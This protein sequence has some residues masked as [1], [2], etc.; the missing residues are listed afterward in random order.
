MIRVTKRQI[1]KSK[2]HLL[3]FASLLLLGACTGFAS[4]QQSQP[5]Y[6]DPHQTLDKRVDD[7]VSRM[8]MEEKISQMQ[9]GAKAIPRLSVP[10]YNWWNEGLHGIARSG[11]AT[12]FPQALGMAATWDKTL[13]HQLGTVTSTEA[14]A[15]HYDAI[16]HNNRSIYY[17]LTIWSPNINI[18]RDPRWGRGQETYGED[19]YLTGQIGVAYIKG[20]QGD[21]PEHPRV[22]AT[23]KHLAAHSG[24]ESQ[25]H[26]FNV[27]PSPHDLEDTY[28]PAFRM[29]ITEGKADSIM[30]AYNAIDG[31]PACANK[32]IEEVVRKSW[33]FQ[34]FVTSDCGAVDDMDSK[35]GHHFAPDNAHA[36]ALSVKAGTDLTCGTEYAKLP[37]ALKANL[38]SEAEIDKAVR[39]LFK[40]RFQLGMFDPPNQRAYAQIPFSEN[41]SPA[42][43]QMA[44]EAAKKS[45][46]LLENSKGFLPLSNKIRSLAV[47]G[48][49][50]ASVIA[51]EG[52]Y[53]GTPS[54]PAVP[55]DAVETEFKGKARVEYS[56]GSPYVVGL[57]L[58]VPR[59][60]FHP[61]PGS[62]ENGLYAEYFN[63]TE[64]AGKPVFT[65]TDAHIDFDWN[66]DAP[67]KGVDPKSFSVRWK[68]TISPPAPGNYSFMVGYGHCD[69]CFDVESYKVYVDGKEVAAEKITEIKSWRSPANK[70][71]DLRFE[72]K[73]EHKFQLE[74]T[75]KAPQFGAGVTFNWQP[76]VEALRAEAVEAAKKAD[77][78]IAFVGLSSELEGEELRVTAEGFSGGDR[79]SLNLPKVQE[80]L[81]DAVGATGKP[82]VL[83]FM[84]GSAI[85]S[86]WMKKAAA[87]LEAWY[88]GQR[89][90]T[91]IAQTL[92][93]E[94]NP[95]GRLPVTFYASTDQLP[96]F[97]EY[98]MKNRTYR[99]FHGE[100]LYGFGY[101]LSYSKFKYSNIRLST[102][103]LKAGEPL[104]VDIDLV[105]NSDVAGEE[106]A[107]VYFVPPQTE[108]SPTSA[109]VGFERI[110]LKPREKKTVHFTVA[111]RQLSLV[112]ADGTR[113]I[114]AG[115]YNLFVGG[116][117]PKH[118]E[119][120]SIE[121]QIDGTTLLPR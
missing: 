59:T 81:L 68:G 69:D 26:H 36:S 62:K 13:I 110:Q 97:E 67:V 93:G 88:P 48:P 32:I 105:N 104:E 50:A 83:V 31:V 7:L 74:Y 121:F 77:A 14:R 119:G 89:G 5:L 101:G 29:A 90:G 38:I 2:Q 3:R 61:K 30:C 12:V 57:P 25:R 120:Q 75:H 106:V 92:T 47:I 54:H 116:G 111:P 117:Q 94:N 35:I 87:V 99:Y 113:S 45:I 41:D 82:I 40:A 65:R 4:A 112:A 72:D 24:P 27:N 60:L 52:N 70:T 44:L 51:L 80:Q 34:G 66:G 19:P 28:L 58:P 43:D 39:R 8:T 63:G 64:F 73:K 15:K 1:S 46:V 79:T 108:L 107:Q 55:L 76:P 42:H 17:G 95:A 21:D 115:S 18:F 22:I 118:A 85:A 98:S 84:N 10:E 71:F 114:T 109:L 37:E 103:K 49:N 6:M 56:Q 20:L 16:A 91:A 100:P 33:N 102:E 78:V 9:N 11:Y 96:P 53:N 23:P 86:P